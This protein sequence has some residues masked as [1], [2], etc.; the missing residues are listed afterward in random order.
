MMLL[1]KGP[2]GAGKTPFAIQFVREGLNSGEYAVYISFNESQRDFIRYAKTLG[3]DIERFIKEGRLR[4][5]DF[6]SERPASIND[7]SIALDKELSSISATHGRVV[8]DSL[9]SLGF[10][11]AL[12][13][14]PPWVL[15]VRAR[16]KERNILGLLILGI[17]VHPPSLDLAMQN[18]CE[19]TLEMKLE[20]LPDGQLR[21]LFRIYSVRGVPHV[22]KW[23]E[24]KIDQSG[25]NFQPEI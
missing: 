1:L 6:F 3:L 17:G 21:R 7:V 25:L 20:E 24:F 4:Y 19:G 16:L 13:V 23:F 15:Q 18:V 22:T 10:V 9:T 14:M 5:I 11:S 8:L 2:V 12:D